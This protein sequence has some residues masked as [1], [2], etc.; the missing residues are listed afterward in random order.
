MFGFQVGQGEVI[1]VMPKLE[2]RTLGLLC[3]TSATPM[4]SSQ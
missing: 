1:A 4:V 2:I 3:L